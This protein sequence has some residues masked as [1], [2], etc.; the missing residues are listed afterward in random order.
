MIADRLFDRYIQ[1]TDFI[2]QYIFPGG[3]LPSPQTFRE[4]AAR[5]GLKVVNEHAF[6]LDYAQTLR[7]WRHTF[8]REE[9][10][11]RALGFD[12]AFIRTWEFY[13]AYCEAAF[14]EANT[15]VIQFT[16]EKSPAHAE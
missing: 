15:D 14:M 6:G 5:A 10:A 7:T 11:V 1:G 9:P 4:S 16:L 12:T 2:Q 8:L 3:C 13:L